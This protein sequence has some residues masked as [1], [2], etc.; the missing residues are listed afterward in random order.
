M[1]RFCWLL[2]T[3]G[4][5][6][7]LAG[8][9]EA[10]HANAKDSNKQPARGEP[11][12]GKN[13]Q[14]S[15]Y[16]TR[17]K[18]SFNNLPSTIDGTHSGG[19]AT[20]GDRRTPISIDIKDYNL[21]KKNPINKPKLEQAART[22][23]VLTPGDN[24]A[25]EVRES[26][27]SP[28]GGKE[29][30]STHNCIGT[31]TLLKGVAP[32]PADGGNGNLPSN[33]RIPTPG[34]VG[35][36]DEANSALGSVSTTGGK[37]IENSGAM[38]EVSTTRGKVI[39]K[40]GNTNPV[41][42]TTVN[43]STSNIKRP[44][45]VKAGEPQDGG[46]KLPSGEK[47]SDTERWQVLSVVVHGSDGNLLPYAKVQIKDESGETTTGTANAAGCFSWAPKKVGKYVMTAFTK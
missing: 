36:A 25:I 14:G 4:L 2:V 33:V 37:V 35:R 42:R 11:A 40:T 32:D 20:A 34:T 21:G 44:Q 38:G 12:A 18:A 15:S 27:N 47:L 23:F 29:E 45:N 8:S 1:S 10:A 26:P 46:G 41:G 43:T 24:F 16:G 28:E 5:A 22:P 17:L 39:E 9:F 30:K 7:T 13:I 3:C 31:V 6:V 19:G